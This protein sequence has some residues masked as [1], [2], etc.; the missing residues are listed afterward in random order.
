MF[1]FLPSLQTSVALEKILNDPRLDGAVV[2]ATVMDTSGRI[3]FGHNSSLHM[4]PASN[5]KLFSNAFAL[6][7]L[8]PTFTPETRF[9]FTDTRTFIESDGDPMMSFDDLKKVATTFH[10]DRHKPVVIKEAYA[11]GVPDSWEL[12]DLPNK[13]AAPITALSFD[14]A[15]FELR[16]QGGKAIL[17][18]ADFGVRI[19]QS[20]AK[21]LKFS[22]DPFA[23]LV[24]VSGPVPKESKVLD[25]L[26]L[27]RADI[28]AAS[29]FG[30]RL[31]LSDKSP[32]ITPSFILKGQSVAEIVSHCLPPSDNNLAEHL[33][34]MAANHQG[35]IK[36][37]PYALA[38]PR[39]TK[40]LTRVAGIDPKDINIYDGSGM[41]RHNFLTTRALCQL[42]NWADRQPTSSLWH[43][44]LAR[45]G[46]GTLAKRLANLKFEG[47]TGS[48]NL[49]ASLSGYLAI[50]KGEKRIVSVVINGYGCTAGETRNI[51]DSFVKAVSVT[52]F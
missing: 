14:R 23:R 29:L 7:E 39:M 28:A 37:N 15:S 36:E 48:L 16:A 25:T 17:W 34:L 8:G 47:K 18:P 31:E 9:W 3:L 38:R 4:T 41:S 22:Y 32:T 10:P 46:S 21:D 12:D 52:G 27:P 2:S 6:Y 30:Q 42:L 26:A 1:G 35:P 51:I 11:P 24:K 33:F 40:F 5:Q 19:E 44:A 45:P 20:S 43:S 49:V 50:E 13:Y